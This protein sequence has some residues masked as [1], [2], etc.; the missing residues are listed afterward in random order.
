MDVLPVVCKQGVR[1]S[2]PLSSTG[3]KHNSNSRGDCTAAKYRNRDRGRCR[4]RVRVGPRPGGRAAAWSAQILRSW[5]GIRAPEQEERLRQSP[6]PPVRRPA[7]NILNL[8]FQ[9][10]FLPLMHRVRNGKL[11]SPPTVRFLVTLHGSRHACRLCILRKCQ[12]PAP[13]A[14]HINPICVSPVNLRW[15]RR[16]WRFPCT[17]RVGYSASSTGGTAG[18]PNEVTRS[19]SPNAGN[20]RDALAVAVSTTML[21]GR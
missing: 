20:A 6:A 21:Y 4:T 2:S 12:R 11:L 7:G 13:H 16:L 17:L 9:G 10:R 5:S 15:S 19:G 1:G 18:K 8:P 14:A 3:Q